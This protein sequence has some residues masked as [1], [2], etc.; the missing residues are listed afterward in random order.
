MPD[1]VELT[2]RVRYA[3]TDQMGV[4]YYANHL[5]WFELG[6]TEFFRRR[7]FVYKE[8]EE[9]ENCY[10][11]VAEVRCRYHA[12]ARYDDVLTVRTWLKAARSRVIQ[13]EYEIVN[14]AGIRI[15]TGETLHVLTD[16]S[17]KPRSP[18]EKYIEALLGTKTKAHR[19]GAPFGAPARGRLAQGKEVAEKTR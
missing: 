2:L 3:E 17:G 19:R 12:P 14:D 9:R 10:A 4:A 18:P 5:V 1:H 7:G 6:R 16:R 8:L 15:A 11:T 13:F